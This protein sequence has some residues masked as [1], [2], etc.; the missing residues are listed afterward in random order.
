MGRRLGKYCCLALKGKGR[1]EVQRTSKV[2][3]HTHMHTSVTAPSS[4]AGGDPQAGALF[5]GVAVGNSPLPLFLHQAPG[6]Q[7]GSLP[8]SPF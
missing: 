2:D 5:H 1:E 3:H 8:I 7:T 4:C 6:A